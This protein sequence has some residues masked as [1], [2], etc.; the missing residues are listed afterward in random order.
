MTLPIMR[1]VLFRQFR[2]GRRRLSSV[3]KLINRAKASSAIGIGIRYRFGELAQNGLRRCF[4]LSAIFF[5][6]RVS[7]AFAAT[8]AHRYFCAGSVTAM[9][10]RN[11]IA[12]RVISP[13]QR[14]MLL[15]RRRWP[16]VVFTQRGKRFP[17]LAAVSPPFISPCFIIMPM[18]A[19]IEGA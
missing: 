16:P 18:A 6:S 2:P 12:C 19:L 3:A 13:R 5:I 14:H 8:T 1:Y 10:Q 7:D 17:H 4:S 11:P 9:T 15:S